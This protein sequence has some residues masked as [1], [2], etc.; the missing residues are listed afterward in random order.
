MTKLLIYEELSDLGIT[1]TRRWLLTLEKTNRFPKR[2]PLGPR[3]VA[4][5][6]QDVRAW[7]N[8]KIKERK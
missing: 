2:V 8:A 5:V 1:Y 7:I 4:W 6:E 3:K